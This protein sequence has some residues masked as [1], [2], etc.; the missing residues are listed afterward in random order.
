MARTKQTAR[1]WGG[2]RRNRP[3]KRPKSNQNNDSNADKQK[4]GKQKANKQK[5]NKQMADRQKT[6]NSFITDHRIFNPD[7]KYTEG[8]GESLDK[9]I[10]ELM[11][12]LEE[13]EAYVQ[14]YSKYFT[15]LKQ[16]RRASEY[17]RNELKE[18]WL[19]ALNDES[20]ADKQF[21]TARQLLLI[22]TEKLNHGTNPILTHS[23][24]E[25]IGINRT[26]DLLD[27]VNPFFIHCVPW[28]HVAQKI[29][30][31]WEKLENE[32]HLRDVF[33]EELKKRWI[34][35]RNKS[36]MKPRFWNRAIDMIVTTTPYSFDFPPYVPLVEKKT[37]GQDIGDIKLLNPAN[38][39][40]VK[41][42]PLR[43]KPDQDIT[44]TLMGF[45]EKFK[46]NAAVVLTCCG[47]VTEASLRLDSH[48]DE[49]KT[50]EQ[51]FEIVSMQGTLYGDKAHLHI[52]LSDKEGHV[53]SGH[54]DGDLTVFTTAEI[55]LGDFSQDW[56]IEELKTNK[57]GAAMLKTSKEVIEFLQ[58]D[59]PAK[60]KHPENQDNTKEAADEAI[61]DV[62]EWNVIDSADLDDDVYKHEI[63]E[64]KE[65][66]IVITVGGVGGEWDD[67]ITPNEKKD[68]DSKVD[69]EI[70]ELSK[71]DD[72]VI[73]L[74]DDTKI[75]VNDTDADKAE[76]KEGIGKE[77]DVKCDEKDNAG[78]AVLDDGSVRQMQM[79]DDIYEV[80]DELPG[81]DGV[82][83][84]EPLENYDFSKVDV[85]RVPKY[86]CH[87]LIQFYLDE[88]ETSQWWAANFNHI[89]SALNSEGLLYK[90]DAKIRYLK[91]LKSRWLG[92]QFQDVNN[93]IHHFK[94]CLLIQHKLGLEED[95]VT[96]EEC[97]RAIHK[98]MVAKGNHFLT[99]PNLLGTE[100]PR[101]VKVPLSNEII[102][103]KEKTLLDDVARPTKQKRFHRN[104]ALLE[105][106]DD[107]QRKEFLESLKLGFMMQLDHST[108]P[109]LKAAKRVRN[110]RQ[111]FNEISLLDLK[112][113]EC[114]LTTAE[115]NYLH[116]FIE[117]QA[118]K[119]RRDQKEQRRW[120]EPMKVVTVHLEEGSGIIHALKKIQNIF[121][122]S[123][124]FILSCTGHV[125]QGKLRLAYS[126]EHSVERYVDFAKRY[127]ITSLVGTMG[128]D[129]LH[130]HTSLKD[131]SGD[132][133]G[134][135]VMSDNDLIVTGTVDIAVLDCCNFQFRREH[136]AGTGYEE[137][138]IVPKKSM[139][140]ADPEMIE[141]ISDTDSEKME[142]KYSWSNSKKQNVAL[143]RK[144]QEQQEQ[145]NKKR[146]IQGHDK[147]PSKKKNE[148]NKARGKSR[149]S[150]SDHQKNEEDRKRREAR[151]RRHRLKEDI[152]RKNDSRSRSR[153]DDRR[154]SRSARQ[155]DRRDCYL[156]D[157]RSPR[158]QRNRKDNDASLYS[159]Y[160]NSGSHG[161][162]RNYSTDVSM[163]SAGSM[164]NM[165]MMNQN[166]G[167]MNQSMG[168]NQSTGG[169]NWNMGMNQGGMGMAN[170]MGM[171]NQL[172]GMN[173]QIMGMNNQTMGMNNQTMGMNNQ[174]MGMNNPMMGTSS[175]MGVNQPIS[176]A[177]GL[178]Q[179]IA[180]GQP[181]NSKDLA[182]SLRK[183]A[184]Q[185]EKTSAPQ[186][187]PSN[188][189]G[190]V[191]G[192]GTS[193]FWSGGSLTDQM[194]SSSVQNSSTTQDS[195]SGQ[196][197]NTSNS[198]QNW[199]LDY[200]GNSS[201][202]MS[203]NNTRKRERRRFKN[204]RNSSGSRRDG[205]FPN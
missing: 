205:G 199:G 28:K 178:M 182:E 162:S 144:Q 11:P 51:D 29:Q 66:N 117:R 152:R 135:H 102:K 23:D 129:G 133:L 81:E 128:R 72:V 39:P 125:G 122:M 145:M 118:I 64:D 57:D 176:Q 184:E 141:I 119:K 86:I 149:D 156:S 98:A 134:G 30:R 196:N 77:D 7:L 185:L 61:D 105:K 194:F 163:G 100:Y 110:M 65:H 83:S 132:I 9:H 148:S 24:L 3:R 56:I 27:V 168:M 181:G 175:N 123:A 35:Y 164:Q 165:G 121:S 143:K 15:Q 44:K 78:N 114:I 47:S 97:N 21:L 112:P 52:S 42:F 40:S 150:S 166:M 41:L 107:K 183:M 79:G 172:M 82:G 76:K 179:S 109:K 54:V 171:S 101:A 13:D 88:S 138:L 49:V 53:I 116:N 68:D 189:G 140:K 139:K 159:G 200:S 80:V 91:Q 16:G 113:T 115:V 202:N 48:P 193:G 31:I 146:A 45:K 2:N 108:K 142:S 32:S 94:T 62:E 69:E 4:T 173:N 58:C 188:I 20:D 99:F 170:Q 5:A 127:E 137:L 160:S 192:I 96:L 75:D 87:A 187:T 12:T 154:N 151:E 95:I 63:I 157:Q 198:S 169:M 103:E 186:Q 18:M 59:D 70:H 90:P 136:D 124:P 26:I 33:Q 126:H 55:V 131:D 204:Q 191:G 43:I 38:V 37:A 8:E 130:L 174:V 92:T 195:I 190:S 203:G 14:L 161:Q 17:Q 177:M 120:K 147:Q 60:A 19:K 201:Q 167:M 104:K 73:V 106:L 1:R 10:Q 84:G 158:G 155:Q 180:L 50:F 22:Q 197:L 111:V 36:E 93:L 85:E 67:A 74:D 6:D 46:L 25:E 71:P 153:T 34:F 89:Q